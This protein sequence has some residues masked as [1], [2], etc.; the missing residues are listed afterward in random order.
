MTLDRPTIQTLIKDI[1]K[2][3][4]Q[5]NELGYR[6][7]LLDCLLS[8]HHIEVSLKEEDLDN[9]WSVF[10]KDEKEREAA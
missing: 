8:N 9:L 4:N 10:K 2:N 7:E 5:V 1:I 3:Y 6:F